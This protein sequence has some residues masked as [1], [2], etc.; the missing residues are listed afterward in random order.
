LGRVVIT[1]LTTAASRTAV[2]NGIQGQS[3]YWETA[4]TSGN[5]YS[6]VC[7]PGSLSTVLSINYYDGYVFPGNTFGTPTGAQSLNVTGLPTGSKINV[8]GTTTILLTVNYYDASGRLVQ[9]K[10]DN[11][12]GG[13]DIV[14]NTYHP[15]TNEL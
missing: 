9:S 15:I 14:T 3:K 8:L 11:Y 10:A 5:G 6:E 13:S 12:V 7:W 4:V 1:G 2:E